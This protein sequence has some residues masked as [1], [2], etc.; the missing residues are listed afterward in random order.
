ML[1]GARR[2]SEGRSFFLQGH[3]K[4]STLQ[5]GGDTGSAPRELWVRVNR[6]WSEEVNQ[7]H[8][9]PLDDFLLLSPPTLI[10]TAVFSYNLPLQLDSAFLLVA[11]CFSVLLTFFATEAAEPGGFIGVDKLLGM[12]SPPFLKSE[13]QEIALE[14]KQT[15][16][17]MGDPVTW[18][19]FIIGR[20]SHVTSSFMHPIRSRKCTAEPCPGPV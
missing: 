16:Q 18:I 9:T 7:S 14:Q 2:S 8:M 6:K 5:R 12:I 13:K 20:A 17:T 1:S 3:F 19:S 4:L 10:F 11:F 15:N